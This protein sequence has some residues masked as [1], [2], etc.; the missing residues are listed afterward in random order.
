LARGG[1]RRA[2]PKVEAEIEKITSK[3]WVRRV[4]T[5]Q[6]TG[7]TP[8]DHR[9]AWHIDQAAQAALED[10]LFGKHVLITG[11][12]DWPVADVVAGYRSQSD[13]EFSFRQMKD[14]HVVSF[15]P[16]HHWTEHNIRA[17]LFTCVLALAIAHLMRRHAAQHQ[18]KMSV[19]V[20]LDTLAGIEETILIYPSTGGRPKARRTLTR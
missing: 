3:T 4:I 12:D 9:L 16:M 5:W 6:L 17:H 18:V 20:L 11:H 8:K 19:R 2:R 1:T 13:A 10:E 14:P 7:D 15:S